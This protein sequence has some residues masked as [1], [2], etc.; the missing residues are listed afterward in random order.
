MFS[1]AEIRGVLTGLAAIAILLLVAISMPAVIPGQELL[2]SLRFHVAGGLLV[3]PILLLL[4]AARGRALILAV[5]I[6]ASLVQGALIVKR[7]LDKRAEMAAQTPVTHFSLLS[8]NVLSGNGRGPDIAAYI[9]RTLP[10]IAVI[11][12]TPGIEGQLDSLAPLYPYRVGCAVSV[13]CDTSLMSRTPLH[14]PKLYLLQ[15]FGRQRL[16]VAKTTIDGQ[17]VTVVA[18]HLSKPYFDEAAWVEL[19]QVR[20]VLH[21][22]T[23]PVVVTGDFNAAAWSEA[24]VDFTSNSHLVPPPRYPATWP[25]RLGPLGVPIDNM[26]SRDGA[27]IESIDALDSSIGSNHRGLLAQIAIMPPSAVSP[28]P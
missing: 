12:E 24:L 7:Q 2:Q 10:D 8:F 27:L 6:G 11:M 9:V 5:L 3:L 28:T 25:V 19:W 15:P 14:D 4:T 16:I 20:D 18:V 22:I 1:K 21:S 13:S 23:G 26:F 17:D